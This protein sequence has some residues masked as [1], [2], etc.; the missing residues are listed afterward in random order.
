MD[1]N[2]NFMEGII[3]QFFFFFPYITHIWDIPDDLN[4]PVNSAKEIRKDIETPGMNYCVCHYYYIIH[5][6]KKQI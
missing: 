1:G 2:K 6:Y 4:I 3:F 5:M